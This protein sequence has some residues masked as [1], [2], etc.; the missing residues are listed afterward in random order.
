MY[1]MHTYFY[2]KI[3]STV[4]FYPASVFT[5]STREGTS[6]AESPVHVVSP[7][8]YSAAEQRHE[9]ERVVAK[10]VKEKEVVKD[11]EAL[12]VSVDQLREVMFV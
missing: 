5:T 12:R 1:V 3:D 8:Q 6:F 11:T 4:L 2:V 9:Q 7:E 10:Q